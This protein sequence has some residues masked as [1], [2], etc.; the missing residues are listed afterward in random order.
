MKFDPTKYQGFIFDMDG[1][2][3]DTMPSHV[4]AWQET[5]RLFD[6]P[7]DGVWLASMGGMPSIKVVAEINKKYQLSLDPQ[8]VVKHKIDGYKQRIKEGELIDCTFTLAK[9]YQGQKKMAIG[10]GSNR[11]NA[12]I[13]LNF[14]NIMELFDSVVTSDDVLAHKPEPDTFLKAAEKIGVEPH[15]CVVFEDT[16]LG[17]KAAQAAGMDCYL[18][19]E[20]ELVYYEESCF[21]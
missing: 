7:F 21:A 5:A 17:A 3:I 6:F 11:V 20:G 1:T 9:D 10:T 14:H 18:V 15:H 12:D 8:K 19:Q 16:L 4:A 2:L 13:L